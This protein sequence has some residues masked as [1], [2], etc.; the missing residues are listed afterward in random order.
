MARFPNVGLG[1]FYS[2]TFAQ[3]IG[4]DWGNF[5]HV[6]RGQ[7]LLMAADF[8]GE[9]KGQAFETFAFLFFDIESNQAWLKAQPQLRVRCRL[10]SRRMAFKSLND[11][12][13]RKALVPFLKQADLIEGILVVFAISAGKNSL[14]D[15]SA[16]GEELLR[17]WKPHVQEKLM[18]VLHLSALF[19]SALSVPGQDFLWF[20]DEDAIAA[21]DALLFELTNI[22]S[23]LASNYLFH[24]LRHLK[25]GTSKSDNEDLQLE[26]IISISDLAAGALAEITTQMTVEQ[27][28]PRKGIITPLPASLT[29]KSRLIG[30]WLANPGLK[31]QRRIF[32]LELHDRGSRLS[33]LGFRPTSLV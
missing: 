16:D 7:T 2:E 10:N 4:C 5:P 29:W 3:A 23:R 31:L 17:F 1:E 11:G 24:D 28:F 19:C 12:I 14:F 26:D 30:S 33:H 6:P 18:R 25:C 15:R 22:F 8:G 13:R 27:L 32:I 21:N 9:N 20:V